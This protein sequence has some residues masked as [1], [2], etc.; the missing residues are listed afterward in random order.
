MALLPSSALKIG[1]LRT[2]FEVAKRLS[3]AQ[4]NPFGMK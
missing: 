4:N 3:Q 2:D 1:L